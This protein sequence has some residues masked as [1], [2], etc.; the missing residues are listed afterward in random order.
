[1][2]RLE[3]LFARHG[4]ESIKEPPAGHMERFGD[5]LSKIHSKRR[6]KRITVFMKIASVLIICLL[7][8][9]IIIF[10]KPNNNELADRRSTELYEA[11]FYY[12]NQINSGIA[13]LK[14]LSLD[15]VISKKEAELL[16]EE[17]TNMDSLL[18][19]LKKEYNSDDE[20]IISAIFNH[21]Q[22]KLVIINTI[23][24]DLKEV[25]QK[26]MISHENTEI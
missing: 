3:E 10:V 9:N 17:L 14:K 20:R 6:G 13:E 15:G 8:T 21:Y 19:K 5:K 12:T 25:K 2:D 26:K 18:V 11:E 22:A 4:E 7:I 1:M 24:Q 23:L 16:N